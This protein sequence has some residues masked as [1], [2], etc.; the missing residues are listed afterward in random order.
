MLKMDLIHFRSELRSGEKII[1]DKIVIN[2]IN[3]KICENGDCKI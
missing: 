2:N 1:S 3:E